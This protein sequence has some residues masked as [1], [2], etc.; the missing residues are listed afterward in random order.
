MRNSVAP[1]RRHTLTTLRAT[2]VILM[3][4]LLLRPVL[5]FTVEGSIRRVLVV[6]C[7]GSASMQIKDP[8]LEENDQKRAAL[9]RDILD[10]A[11]GFNQVLDR[12][13]RFTPLLLRK[14]TAFVRTTGIS[15]DQARSRYGLDRRRVSRESRVRGHR[16]SGPLY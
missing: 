1:W 3:L 8:R 10:P 9:A 13:G 12:S 11:K 14:L 4:A 15:C 16:W 6:L 7:D 2:F 5:A